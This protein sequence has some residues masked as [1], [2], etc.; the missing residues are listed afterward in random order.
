MNEKSLWSNVYSPRSMTK[1]NTSF[2]EYFREQFIRDFGEESAERVVN[3]A[4]GYL[5]DMDEGRAPESQME[6]NLNHSINPMMGFFDGFVKYGAD[7][8]KVLPYLERLWNEAPD[9][10]RF[11]PFLGAEE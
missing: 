10:I 6:M 8:K 1:L 3:Y 5:S 9:K 7:P 11:R 4:Y 2:V